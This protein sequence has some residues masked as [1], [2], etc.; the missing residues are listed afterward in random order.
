MT[1]TYPIAAY[2]TRD[3]RGQLHLAGIT[4]APVS[5][6]AA[7]TLGDDHGLIGPIQFRVAGSMSRVNLLRRCAYE[8]KRAHIEAQY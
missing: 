1:H 2:V 8:M 6:W 4:D 5:T 7:L 3:D